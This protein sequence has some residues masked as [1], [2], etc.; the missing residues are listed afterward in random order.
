MEIRHLVAPVFPGCLRSGAPFL[1]GT[2]TQEMKSEWVA[3]MFYFPGCTLTVDS[4]PSV[5][6]RAS[7]DPS[8]SRMMRGPA[9]PSQAPEQPAAAQ[10]INCYGPVKNSPLNVTYWE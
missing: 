3:K 7:L 6:D 10:L 5:R 2:V 4:R 1:T 8:P 9:P